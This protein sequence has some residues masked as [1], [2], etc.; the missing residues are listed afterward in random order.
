MSTIFSRIING[1]IPGRFVWKDDDV[2][3]FL[4]AGPLTPG[5]TMVVPREEVDHWLDAP[6]ELLQRI[7]SVA[8]I[9]GEAQQEVFGSARVGL[10][11]MGFEVPHLHVHVWPVNSE[12]DFDLRNID[13]NPDPA[14]MDDAAGKIREALRAA[15][16][17]GQVP[18][19]EA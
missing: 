14:E 19:A 4:T 2:V 3:A 12:K 17:A 16:H 15:G 11:V 13:H 5:H 10:M 9:I 1:E 8:K 6:D 18:E 7:M